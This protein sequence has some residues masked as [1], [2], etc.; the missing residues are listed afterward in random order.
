MCC[1]RIPCCYCPTGIGSIKGA[2]RDVLNH[3]TIPN[4]CKIREI[5]ARERIVAFA[6][7]FFGPRSRNHLAIKNDNDT[8]CELRTRI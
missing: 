3:A 1:S 7:F 6:L 8:G 5:N 4:D 2:M